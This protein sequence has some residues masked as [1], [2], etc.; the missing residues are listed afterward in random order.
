[1]QMEVRRLPS[2][3][4]GARFL[5]F[6][7]SHRRETGAG[8]ILGTFSAATGMPWWSALFLGLGIALVFSD[9]DSR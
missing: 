4:A 8:S 1:M 3:G 5:A 7:S 9:S 6:M 2:A